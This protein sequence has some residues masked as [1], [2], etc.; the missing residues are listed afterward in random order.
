MASIL[1]EMNR[2]G[3]TA[4]S[5][6]KV[7]V[8]RQTLLAYMICMVT[9]G[10]GV[11]TTG[12]TTTRLPPEMIALIK[13]KIATIVLRAAGRGMSRQVSA[14]VRRDFAFWN[15]MR[16]SLPGFEWFVT[17]WIKRGY[18]Q[19]VPV[20]P[21]NRAASCATRA[22]RDSRHAPKRRSNRECPFAPGFV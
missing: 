13:A 8:F 2:A 7:G 5:Q 9:C 14:A 18:K 3:F 4:I 21:E 10:N 15:R 22:S 1:S 19:A 17:E 20:Y 11:R 6:Q 16:M 12:W